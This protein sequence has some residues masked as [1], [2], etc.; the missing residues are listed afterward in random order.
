MHDTS[1][2]IGVAKATI[3]REQSKDL[4]TDYQLQFP[5]RPAK[6]MTFELEA[7]K[8][9]LLD[10]VRRA[11]F[12]VA[13]R[14]NK[15]PRHGLK[16][17]SPYEIVTSVDTDSEALILKAIRQRFPHDS[18]LSEETSRQK[19]M[20]GF[21]WI[22]DPLDGTTNFFIGNPVF[23]T[24]IGLAHDGEMVVGATYHPITKQLFLVEGGKGFS[25][26]GKKTSVSQT[27]NL[28]DAFVAFCHGT[29]DASVGKITKIFTRLKPKCRSLRQLGSASFEL[30]LVAAGKVDAFLMPGA[31][32]WDVAAGSLMVREAGGAVLDFNGDEWSL[33][34]QH[35]LAC[36]SE[37]AKS[38]LPLLR[39]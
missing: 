16:S 20:Q 13:S 23:T 39:D 19:V 31:K 2:K 8:K 28:S 26:N 32:P 37:M 14:F 12:L 22:V 33:N 35:L 30:A 27:S 4:N 3:K 6:N 10:V 29:D 25:V 34:S 7:R 9:L 17:K 38:I 21:L 18:I 36:N 24:T 5:E 15:I 11:G 1:L